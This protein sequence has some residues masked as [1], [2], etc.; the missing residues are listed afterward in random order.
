MRVTPK[1]R[2]TWDALGPDWLRQQLDREGRRMA[3]AKPA[4]GRK[5]AE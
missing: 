5:L 1:Q 4:D 3:K 2:A